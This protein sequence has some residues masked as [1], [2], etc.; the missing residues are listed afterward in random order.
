MT[1]EFGVA[2][3][4]L[5]EYIEIL[6]QELLF[7]MAKRK[8]ESTMRMSHEI[9]TIR[10]ELDKAIQERM[11]LSRIYTSYNSSSV[12]AAVPAAS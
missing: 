8:P 5:G 10:R 6:K 1:L 2:V 3:K 12:V 4:A 11:K 7:A 9:I